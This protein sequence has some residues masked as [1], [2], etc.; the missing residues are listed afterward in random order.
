VND[1]MKTLSCEQRALLCLVRR[2]MWSE[3]C[4]LPTADWSIVE[5]LAKE[6][7]I[8][9]LLYL[10]AKYYKSQISVERIQ[11][12]R[13]IMLATA[14]RNEQINDTQNKLIAWM[15]DKSIR[16]AVL[17]GTSCSRFYQHPEARSLGDIDI[18]IDPNYMDEI[19]DHL[20]QMGYKP[21]DQEHGFH[22]GYY[23]DGVVIEIHFAVTEP[24][25]CNG[26]RVVQEAMRCFLDDVH[27]EVIGDISFPVLSDQNQ[28]LALL[29]HMERHMYEC[30]IGLRQMC[31]WASFMSGVSLE[32]WQNAIQPL[33]E[34]CGLLT[35][36]KVIT[37]TCVD[38]LGLD[39]NIVPW[40]CDVDLQ[41]AAA[42]INDVFCQGSLGAADRD[43]EGSWFIDRKALGQTNGGRINTL[44]RNMNALAYRNWPVTKT[45]KVLL[46]FC[47]VYLPLRYMA[48]SLKGLRAKKNW[49]R[50]AEASNRRQKLYKAMR[51]YEI[52]K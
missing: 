19:R 51:L 25:E 27:Q 35:Y 37:K 17:K 22:V 42:M 20:L 40:C 28:A 14:I 43:G 4:D 50:M 21:S 36:A 33:I 23:G 9:W 45:R 2:A 7:G 39:S 38:Y 13:G 24:P 10:G 29:L 49:I 30:G 46:P 12:W 1:K 52:E 44:L 26:G 5:N 16:V 34:R 32:C 18:L 6:Q 8:S 11:A 3:V 47:W 41:L 15:R 48:R 31:D